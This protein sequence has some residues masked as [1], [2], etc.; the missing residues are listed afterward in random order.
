MSI[1]FTFGEAVLLH[2]LA[3]HM[4][5][6]EASSWQ[7]IWNYVCSTCFR[8]FRGETVGIPLPLPGL[9]LEPGSSQTQIGSNVLSTSP[10]AYALS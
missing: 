7:E 5:I 4:A 2:G 6:L 3:G 8:S 1:H 9:G 10:A